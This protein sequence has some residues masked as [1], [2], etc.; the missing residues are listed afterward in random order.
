[1]NSRA[2]KKPFISVSRSIRPGLR[3]EL[4]SF[5]LYCQMCGVA[6]GEE[7]ELTGGPAKLHAFHF[8]NNGLSGNLRLRNVRVLCSTCNQG[9]KNITTEKPSEVWLLS[10]IRRAGIKEQKAVFEWLKKKFN[11]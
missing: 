11:A 4:L 3:R 6:A 2:I 1:M 5:D 8:P 10:Q 7:D 9:A